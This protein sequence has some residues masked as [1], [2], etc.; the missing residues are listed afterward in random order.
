MRAKLGLV[1]VTITAMVGLSISA[2]AAAEDK[3][4]SDA[5]ALPSGGTGLVGTLLGALPPA[6][7]GN[8]RTYTYPPGTHTG[9]NGGTGLPDL[10]PAT[11]QAAGT[12][13]IDGFNQ[14]RNAESGDPFTGNT[15]AAA[16]TAG[17]TLNL[18]SLTGLL[19][20]TG[21]GF[22]DPSALL[23]T[24][25]TVVGGV[26]LTLS[27]ALGT[28]LAPVTN[29]LQGVLDQLGLSTLKATIGA[30]DAW[31]DAKPGKA[32]ASGRVAG[33]Q[34]DLDL[35]AGDSLDLHVNIPIGELPANSDV[36]VNVPGLVDA[37]V[38]SLTASLQQSLG[39]IGG[40][41]ATIVATLQSAI[42]SQVTAALRPV[43]QQLA[44][45]LGPLAKLTINKTSSVPTGT[46]APFS[47][48]G[49]VENLALEGQILPAIPQ[50]A[51]TLAIAHV[52][53]GPNSYHGSNNGGKTPRLQFDKDADVKGS[54]EVEW[55][56][57]VRNPGADTQTNVVVSDDMPDVKST[58]VEKISQGTYKNGVWNVGD[59]GAHKTAT[60]ILR[61]D[62][63]KGDL[64][65][66]L[67]NKACVGDH[68]KKHIQKN[69][70]LKDDK[71][72]CDE[73]TAQKDKKKDHPKHINSGVGSSG[74]LSA[75]ALAGLVAMTA[76]GG[77]ALRRRRF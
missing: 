9:G 66:G 71:D 43:F 48:G 35:P 70:S 29:A 44:D 62:V 27:Q 67:T 33:V 53:C 52:H 15:S 69:K 24:L 23:G 63:K 4:E 47:T 41:A 75:A 59:L 55:T 7:I 49:E 18:G 40:A 2:A 57:T 20:A 64:D 50:L 31:C 30:V 11:Y 77:T 22:P 5:T 38:A 65:D 73:I 37:L 16:G 10:V 60:L 6:L 74:D 61:S 13:V 42:I 1:L 26:T 51:G 72:G 34:V 58:H 56:L 46:A 36:I 25:T 14:Q 68:I 8:T 21:P 3:G 28:A 19:D 12:G 17:V 76:M 39:A 54:D 45:G 32:T